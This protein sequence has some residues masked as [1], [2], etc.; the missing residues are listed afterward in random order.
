M[1]IYFLA[2]RLTGSYF[3]QFDPGITTTREVQQRIIDDLRRNHVRLVVVYRVTLPDEP[4]KSRASSG[5]TL[6]DDYFAENFSPIKIHP[7][8]SISPP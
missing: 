4:N 3:A 8:Y 5:V 7:E 2:D 6:L 1:T